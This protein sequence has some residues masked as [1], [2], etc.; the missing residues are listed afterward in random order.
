MTSAL[1]DYIQ[2]N[3]NNDIGIYTNN[4]ESINID[5]VQKV[6]IPNGEFEV[7]N[8]LSKM[9]LEDANSDIAEVLQIKRT[10]SGTLA[11]GIG[12]SVGFY[13]EA[14]AGEGKIGSIDFSVSD[15]GANERADFVV[16]LMRNATGSMVN[17]INIDSD[18]DDINI[19]ISAGT[20]GGT[21]VG[22]AV[23]IGAL[24]RS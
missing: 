8:A 16:Q 9:F 4:I 10:T 24:A 11:N 18:V 20:A 2:Y 17:V 5:S 6:T 14:T 21:K 13:S 12:A 1:N 23:S 15:I 19:G 7:S 22:N 3:A